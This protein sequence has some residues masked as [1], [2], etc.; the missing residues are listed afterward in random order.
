MQRVRIQ[1]RIWN[2][3]T[4]SFSERTPGVQWDLEKHRPPTKRGILSVVSAVWS[5]EISFPGC[6]ES[7]EDYAENDEIPEDLQSH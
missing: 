7:S 3:R 2:S 6:L 4:F 1:P 5:N